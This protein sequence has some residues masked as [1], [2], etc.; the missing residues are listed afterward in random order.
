MH[1]KCNIL[2]TLF[3]LCFSAVDVEAAFE[4]RKLMYEKMSQAGFDHIVEVPFSRKMKL[5]FI[6]EDGSYVSKQ[7]TRYI[8]EAEVI[9]VSGLDHHLRKGKP[10]RYAYQIGEIMV[11]YIDQY[12]SFMLGVYSEEADFSDCLIFP[13]KV[14]EVLRS[15][16]GA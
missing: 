6:R 14:D 10:R 3:I 11:C 4:T 15:M 7:V 5:K 2:F 13:H 9:R 16:F 1:L 8:E 12:Y